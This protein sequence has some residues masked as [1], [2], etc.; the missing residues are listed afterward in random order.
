MALLVGYGFRAPDRPPLPARHCGVP[1]RLPSAALIIVR[2]L[3]RH[4][5][6]SVSF[7]TEGVIYAIFL[8]HAHAR[9]P[10]RIYVGRT[11]GTALHRFS[12]H[13]RSAFAPAPSFRTAE[14]RLVQFIRLHGVQQLCVVPLQEVMQGALPEIRGDPHMWAIVSPVYERFWIQVLRS[15]FREQSHEYMGLN[16]LMPGGRGTQL[17]A[18][19]RRA[20]SRVPLWSP[21]FSLIPGALP[22]APLEDYTR[23]FGSSLLRSPPYSFSTQILPFRCCSLRGPRCPFTLAANH[24]LQVAHAV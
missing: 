11:I 9:E 1:G 19:I 12:Q 3:V 17:G 15:L 24:P 20:A 21:L 16:M 10:V 23:I 4:D 8:R 7:H 2:E 18:V 22:H 13:L 6:T 14:T 5:L